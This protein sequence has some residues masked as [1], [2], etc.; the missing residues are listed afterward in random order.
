LLKEGYI[1][2]YEVVASAM[3]TLPP[4]ATWVAKHKDMVKEFTWAKK[5]IKRL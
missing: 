4:G 3:N 1:L 5:W 2:V